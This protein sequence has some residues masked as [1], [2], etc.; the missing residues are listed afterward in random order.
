MD[1][2]PTAPG[3]PE[4]PAERDRE[5]AVDVVA[6]EAFGLLELRRQCKDDGRQLLVFSRPAGR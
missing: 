6:P 3:G 1:G 4:E 2:K 5:G